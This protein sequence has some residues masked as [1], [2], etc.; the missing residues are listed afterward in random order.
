MPERQPQHGLADVG[1]FR[2]FRLLKFQTRRRVEEQVADL[3]LRS[4]GNSDLA[5]FGL[6]PRLDRHPKPGRSARH[7]RRQRQA[8]H[9][10][11]RRQRLAT[12][13][14]R[15]QSP[16][17]VRAANLGR[18]VPAQGQARLVGRHA[19]PSSTTRIDRRPPPSISTSIRWAPAS[20]EFSHNSLTT[21]A[22]RSTTSPAA[23]WSASAGGSMAIRGGVIGPGMIAPPD[24]AP[25]SGRRLS[26]GPR[27]RSPPFAA[28]TPGRAATINPRFPGSYARVRRRSSR[29]HVAEDGP[30]RPQNWD[31]PGVSRRRD[32]AGRHRGVVGTM[33]GGGQTNPRGTRICRDSTGIRRNAGALGEPSRRRLRK[34]AGLE[35]TP[36]V[37][38][39]VRLNPKIWTSSRLA[40]SCAPPIF[41]SLATSS[42]WSERPRARVTRAS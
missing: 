41:S 37:L 13:P 8:R 14:E 19:P 16:Q 2:A 20:I 5:G 24:P 30:P 29:R 1:R 9:G 28:L 23:I 25:R 35:K 22:A 39:E 18:R 27:W 40:R 36:R 6:D 38:R 32:R 3:D 42:T 34:K 31:D 4:V 17:I 21:D 15:R 7:L 12:K 33:H 11:D 26:A 10:R